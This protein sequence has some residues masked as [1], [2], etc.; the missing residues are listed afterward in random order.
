[1]KTKGIFISLLLLVLLAA[2]CDDFES[3]SRVELPLE[4]TI[5]SPENAEI[6]REVAKASP[7]VVSLDGYADVWIKTPKRT[8]KVFCNI[9]LNR[10]NQARMIV[11]SG[12]LGWPV[13]DM[14]FSRDSL[15]VHDLIKNRLFLGSNNEQNL[16]KMLGV[17]SGYRMLTETLLG[18]VRISEP[19]SAIRSVSRGQGKLQFTVG[20]PGG[21]KELVVDTSNRTL[22]ALVLRDRN[23]K[24]ATEIHFSAFE[25]CRVGGNN[26]LVPKKIEMVIYRDGHQEEGENQLVISY[27]E[28][29]LKQDTLSLKFS[30]PAKARVINLD[31]SPGLPWL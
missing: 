6:Y 23:G 15:Y 14:Y 24:A 22:R 26:V 1:M 19:E 31:E 11:T 13:A 18:L 12:L 5:L 3:V 2:G 29:Q 27:D 7:F 10:G 20:T 16:E 21:S 28:R 8:E 30:I 4:K 25:I 17:N 9:R